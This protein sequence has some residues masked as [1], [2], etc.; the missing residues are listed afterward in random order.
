MVAPK[1]IP[2]LAVSW[3]PIEVTWT[4]LD[5]KEEVTTY[6]VEYRSFISR[7]SMQVQ[8]SSVLVKGL[9]Q[10]T[11]YKVSVRGRNAQNAGGIPQNSAEVK[12][13]SQ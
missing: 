6:E 8:G 11:S 1:I 3:E 2:A 9:S 7:S 12:T 10:Y 13:L 4:P 5:Q